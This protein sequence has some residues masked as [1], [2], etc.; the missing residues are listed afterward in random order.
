MMT[1]D[2]AQRLARK[3]APHAAPTEIRLHL[4][5]IGLL[6]SVKFSAIVGL[7]IAV[8]TFMGTVLM[9]TM[10]SRSGGFTQLD[11]LLANASEGDGDRFRMAGPVR[12]THVSGRE[13][14][15]PARRLLRGIDALARVCRLGFIVRDEG[16]HIYRD[17]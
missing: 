5:R 3:S 14:D 17:D 13:C 8:L 15:A 11:A 16:V 7:C 2:I 4:A 12:G 6:S 1:D 10:V 9:W